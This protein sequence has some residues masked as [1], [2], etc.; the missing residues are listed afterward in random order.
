MSVTLPLPDRA[1]VSRTVSGTPQITLT[2]TPTEAV[3]DAEL[4]PAMN[5][6]GVALREEAVL[7]LLLEDLG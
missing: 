4:A 2:G 6:L 3:W 7:D 5:A 1:A